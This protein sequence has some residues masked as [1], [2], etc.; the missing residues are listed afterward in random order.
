MESEKLQKIKSIIFWINELKD[1]QTYR[2]LCERNKI[3]YS[4]PR[5][6][7][8]NKIFKFER[9]IELSDW[10]KAMFA[11]WLDEQSKYIQGLIDE[12][13]QELVEIAKNIVD[14]NM[15]L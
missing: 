12:S 14:G 8:V 5:L 9:E 10:A 13:D 15:E 6:R 7:F 1:I 3:A 2:S 4:K 11:D